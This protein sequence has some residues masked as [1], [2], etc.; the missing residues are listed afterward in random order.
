MLPLCTVGLWISEFLLYSLDYLFL[1][2]DSSIFALHLFL[3]FQLTEKPFVSN[4]YYTF[5]SGGYIAENSKFFDM[6]V[7][8]VRIFIIKLDFIL[9]LKLK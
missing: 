7:F 2:L 9:D 1:P 3:S 8:Y 4:Q 6:T 5:L